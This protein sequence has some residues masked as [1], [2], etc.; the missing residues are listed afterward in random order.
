MDGGIGVGRAGRCSR[1][2]VLA[3]VVAC[4]SACSSG[5]SP[6]PTERGSASSAQSEQSSSASSSFASS[7][8]GS[9]WRS[10]NPEPLSVAQAPPKST[11]GNLFGEPPLLPAGQG[12]CL[13]PE[14]VRN[15]LDTLLSRATG[16]PEAL[17]RETKALAITAYRGDG[18]PLLDPNVCVRG[19]MLEPGTTGGV[20]LAVGVIRYRSDPAAVQ[21]VSDAAPS[22]V[23]VQLY[24]G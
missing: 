15:Q 11:V 2:C 9:R 6:T 23:Q 3:V 20:A 7:E 10:A 21:A 8:L 22:D 13:T 24:V 17:G 12:D 18:S 14:Q 4:V 1:G 19:I 16:V 5:T